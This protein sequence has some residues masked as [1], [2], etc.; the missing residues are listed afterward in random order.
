M[1]NSRRTGIAVAAL[2][3]VALVGSAALVVGANSGT[4]GRTVATSVGN[5]VGMMGTPQGSG[6]RMMVGTTAS[7]APANL[8][9]TTVHVRLANMG[10]AMMG[11]GG[12][13]GRATTAPVRMMR[14][15]T[16]RLSVPAGQVSLVAANSGSMTHELVILPLATGQPVGTRAVGADNRV[17]ET[18]SLGEASR[19][20]SAG[21]GEGIAAGSTGW[22]TVLLRPGRYELVCNIAGHYRA[23]MYAELD[24]E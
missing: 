22:V 12:M 2:A 4:G 6:T 7:C 21:A 10:G 19:S 8:P 3:A 1:S 14:I 17:S 24:V 13:M 23:G 5:R 11:S 18:G 9:G 16:D 20:C 15:A